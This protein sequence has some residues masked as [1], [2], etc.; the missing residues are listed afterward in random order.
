MIIQWKNK[1]IVVEAVQFT[2][3]NIGEVME[4]VGQENVKTLYQGSLYSIRTAQGHAQML[5]D[6]YIVK[7]SEGTFRPVHPKTFHNLYERHLVWEDNI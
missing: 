3:A 5:K 7:D 1:P 6:D 2:G 4:F